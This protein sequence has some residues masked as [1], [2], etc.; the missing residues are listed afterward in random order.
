MGKL[1]K[2]LTASGLELVGG[3]LYLEDWDD[4]VGDDVKTLLRK[5]QTDNGS[6]K[7]E[8]HELW[9]KHNRL[10]TYLGLEDVT[11]PQRKEIRKIKKQLSQRLATT[12]KPA[13]TSKNAKPTKP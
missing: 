8:L 12:K 6:L 9:D 1:D 3:Q 5:V 11:M 7:A 13:K 10:L 4:E 2:I